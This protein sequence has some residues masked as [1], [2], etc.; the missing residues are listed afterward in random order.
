MSVADAVLRRFRLDGSENVVKA[1]LPKREAVSLSAHANAACR[2]FGVNFPVTLSYTDRDGSSIE[3]SS[4]AGLELALTDHS[5]AATG[6]EIL[7][8]VSE[9]STTRFP[10]SPRAAK[11]V[12][13]TQHAEMPSTTSIRIR[14][15]LR[16]WSLYGITTVSVLVVL[17]CLRLAYNNLPKMDR[18]HLTAPFLSSYSSDTLLSSAVTI[19]RT[20]PSVENLETLDPH[21]VEGTHRRSENL[22][23]VHPKTPPF[24]PAWFTRSTRERAFADLPPGLSEDMLRLSSVEE[25]YANGSRAVLSLEELTAL[26]KEEIALV[27]SFFP[28]RPPLAF[29]I[30]LD[31]R[32]D[33]LNETL[34]SWSD[35]GVRLLRVSARKTKSNLNGCTLT[36]LSLILAMEEHG[37]PYVCFLED[38]ATA[39]RPQWDRLFPQVISYVRSLHGDVG[40]INFG[41]ST[42]MGD[43]IN[44]VNDLLFSTWGMQAATGGIYGRRMIPA[45]H[46]LLRIIMDQP[47]PRL[48][49]AANDYAFGISRLGLRRYEDLLVTSE[50]IVRPRKSFSDIEGTYVDYSGMFEGTARALY[51]FRVSK[52]LIRVNDTAATASA[53]HASKSSPT[54]S[55]SAS[56]TSSVT[57]SLTATASTS[58]SS[59]QRAPVAVAAPVIKSPAKAPPAAT[60]L[61][62]DSTSVDTKDQVLHGQDPAVVDAFTDAERMHGF[63]KFMTSAYKE[64]KDRTPKPVAL[65][66]A[67]EAPAAAESTDEPPQSEKDSEPATLHDVVDTLCDVVFHGMLAGVSV[68]VVGPFAPRLHDCL[69]RLSDELG[70]SARGPIIVAQ[71]HEQP[72]WAVQLTWWMNGTSSGAQPELLVSPRLGLIVAALS[73]LECSSGDG[74]SEGLQRCP[75]AICPRCT[76]TTASPRSLKIEGAL[77]LDEC[78]SAWVTRQVRAE[79]ARGRRTHE[80]C[81]APRFRAS[82]FRAE[83]SDKLDTP[84]DA[85]PVVIPSKRIELSLNGATTVAQVL[86]SLGAEVKAQGHVPAGALKFAFDESRTAVDAG[87]SQ[88]AVAVRPVEAPRP[89]PVYVIWLSMKRKRRLQRLLDQLGEWLS[90]VTWVHAELAGSVCIGDGFVPIQT[91]TSV[92][93]SC[94]MSHGKAAWRVL[95][96]GVD[97]ALV[98]E[99]DVAFHAAAGPMIASARDWLV[100]QDGA[101]ADAVQV[102]SVGYLPPSEVSTLVAAAFDTLRLACST[103]HAPPPFVQ[104]HGGLDWFEAHPFSGPWGTADIL[105]PALRMPWGLQ[106]GPWG[107]CEKGVAHF[108]CCHSSQAY[109]MTRKGAS[110]VA[111]ALF[112]PRILDVRIDMQRRGLGRQASVVADL[113]VPQITIRGFMRPQVRSLSFG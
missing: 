26:Y 108:Y 107:A 76:E 74:A 28:T 53:I 5:D 103:T 48:H 18:L 55:R 12:L 19:K 69:L 15:G 44:T 113:I 4:D 3:I 51:S 105:W 87:G 59:K 94:S 50:H 17:S 34:R 68:Q 79:V 64:L 7:I 83:R 102:V 106:V 100:S 101:A 58:P 49:N 80:S 60:E 40:W 98:I 2:E 1:M 77:G 112:R 41:P 89:V 86:S 23:A 95:R 67:D 27:E 71:P 46:A 104:R 43:L 85:P 42:L 99:D 52:G 56:L 16:G 22:S 110:A 33:R 32:S 96:D 65:P 93:L 25:I 70:H 47:V 14:G 90:P 62:I 73:N 8:L 45:A 57:P 20:T 38:D 31:H 92:V 29:V 11:L 66:A 81:C 21:A 97:A 111:A 109:V 13:G 72:D 84:G 6:R 88:N 10:T 9:T 78:S 30:N 54:P 63:L 24:K 61:R 37:W 75:R 82:V 35:A 36:H 39:L 91:E